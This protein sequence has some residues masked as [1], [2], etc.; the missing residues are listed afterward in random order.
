MPLP[1]LCL[2]AALPAWQAPAAA[3]PSSPRTS[4]KAS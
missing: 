3:K 1:L 4:S 2:M